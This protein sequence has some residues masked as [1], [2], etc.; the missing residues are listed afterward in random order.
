MLFGQVS[1]LE[2]RRI[3]WGLTTF[4]EAS[5]LEINNDKSQ[6]YFFNT[7][8]ITKRNILIILRFSEGKLPSKYLG[9]PM[10][11]STIRQVSWKDLLD[12]LKSRLNV[13]THRSLN[14]PSRLTLV[15]FILQAMPLYLFSFLAAPKMILKQIHTLQRNLLWG[16]KDRQKKW[17]LLD[18]ATLCT[19]KKAGGLD[20]RDSEVVNKV[21]GAKIWWR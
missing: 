2:A 19:P 6:V 10:A 7:P 15:K 4:L 1:V 21:M 18:W 3:K 12:R 8:I 17:A 5:G 9:K 14:F 13:W 20:L 16:G 11:E